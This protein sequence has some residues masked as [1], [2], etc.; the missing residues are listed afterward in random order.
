MRSKNQICKSLF[1]TI[2]CAAAVAMA[3]AFILAVFAAES[4]QAQT[5]TER[6][7]YSF[8]GSPDGFAPVAA[9][10]RDAHGNLYGTTWLGGVPCVFTEAGCGTVFMSD[11]A[12]KERVL[13]SFT[14]AG[15]DGAEPLGGLA[16]DGQ[17]NLYGTTYAGGVYL[18]GYAVGTVFQVSLLTRSSASGNEAILHNFDP[19]GGDGA[20]PSSPD[21]LLDAGGNLYGATSGG[22]A[23]GNGTVFKLDA[24]G[25]ETVLYSFTGGGDGGAPM[26]A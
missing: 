13:H 18:D 15:G 11:V 25:K 2:S 3:I 26:Q 23:Y 10:V 17:G 8:T 20:R 14:G 12:G 1:R 9:L 6:V 16:L 7:L 22:G 21:P 24:T 5:Y 19:F 4:A